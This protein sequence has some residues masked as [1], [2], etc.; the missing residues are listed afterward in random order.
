MGAYFNT[1]GTLQILQLLNN[2]FADANF[3]NQVVPNANQY[4]AD[5]QDTTVSSATFC[6]KYK[7]MPADKNVVQHWKKWLNYFDA[8]DTNTGN[9]TRIAI[10][11]AINDANCTGIEFYAV[12]NKQWGGATPTKFDDNVNA[13]KYMLIIT[14]MTPTY[15]KLP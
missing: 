1:P 6:T 8:H 12:P 5:L 11:N 14:V 3:Q 9:A 7:L 15:D 4:S 13:G 2:H 10:S